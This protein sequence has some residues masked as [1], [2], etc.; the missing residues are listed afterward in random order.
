MSSGIFTDQFAECLQ[1]RINCMLTTII[2]TMVRQDVDECTLAVEA[3]TSESMP[4]PALKAALGVGTGRML[5]T[6]AT[7]V[8]TLVDISTHTAQSI[9]EYLPLD[10]M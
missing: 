4:T 3:V 8:T 7:Q 9:A 1:H 2:M 5:M 10:A 6:V